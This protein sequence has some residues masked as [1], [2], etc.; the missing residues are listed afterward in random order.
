MPAPSLQD[1]IDQAGSPMNLLWKP[2]AAPWIGPR[3]ADEFVGWHAEQAS[4][5]E[6]V[7]LY[8]LS[9]HMSDLFLSGPDAARLLRETTANNYDTFA[10]G[11]AKQIV[12]V[13]PGGDLIADGILLRTGEDSY[14]LTGAPGSQNWLQYH[15]EAGDY[16]VSLEVDPDMSRRDGDPRLLR[17]QVQGPLAMEV[18]ERALGGPAPDVRFFHSAELELGGR[19]VRALRHGMAGAPGFEFSGDYADYEAV[20]QALLQAGEPSGLVQVGAL[21]YSTTPVESGWVASPQP[22][23]YDDPSLAA[24]RAWLGAFSF[25]GQRPIHGSFYSDDIRDYYVSPWELGYG[26]SISFEHEFIGK[27]ALRAAQATARR[28]KVTLEF[29]A[30]PAIVAFG[31][32]FFND[33]GIHRI[34]ADGRLVGVTH[35]LSNI[36]GRHLGLALVDRD[37]AAPGT[38]VEVV[39][40]EH[41]GHGTAPDADLGFPRI[42]ATVQPSPYDEYA[43]TAY[44]A[45]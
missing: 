14:V 44:R 13:S 5:H 31:E 23:I 15:A 17:F 19:R 33:R 30:A 41:P 34:E 7:A 18:V 37:I 6:S 26:R 39:W 43:R 32:D 28:V 21:A 35:H 1:A 8:D 11:Q 3:V 25:E 22:A 36:R 10:V 2:G 45:G 9:F 16:D 27:E 40:G 24:Y 4:W 20:K 29:D 42:G 38:R 12:P